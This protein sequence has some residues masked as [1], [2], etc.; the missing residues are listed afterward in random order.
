MFRLLKKIFSRK[1]KS[2]QCLED[3]IKE[4][5]ST[6]RFA[7]SDGHLQGLDS[8]HQSWGTWML[9]LGKV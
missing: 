7:S 2:V 8:A 3:V 9:G 4:G 5:V 1:G 6:G